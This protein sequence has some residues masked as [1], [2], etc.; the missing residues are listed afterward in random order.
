MRRA[1]RTKGQKMV[2]AIGQTFSDETRSRAV[3][4]DDLKVAANEAWRRSR[5]AER[6]LESARDEFGLV[7]KRVLLGLA[8]EAEL[9]A[10]EEEIAVFER[11][12][13]RWS[14]AARVLDEDR[15]VLRDEVGNR[16]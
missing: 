5:S 10:L 11:E 6:E 2:E 14:A 3:T 15:G 12:A 8:E 9:I 4:P 1:I 7:A 13:R 16:I